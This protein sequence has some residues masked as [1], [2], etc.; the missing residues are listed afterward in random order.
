MFDSLLTHT[1]ATTTTLGQ[2]GVC[3]LLFCRLLPVTILLRSAFAV[4][5][6][7]RWTLAIA[8]LMTVMLAP[9]VNARQLSD[10]MGAGSWAGAALR[11]L[12]V[13]LALGFGFSILLAGFQLAGAI[14]GQ[15]SGLRWDEAT[16][17][18]NEALGANVVQRYHTLLALSVFWV[19]GGHRLLVEQLMSSLRSIP[20]GSVTSGMDPM[21][22]LQLLLEHSTQMG[23]RT[24]APLV[25]CL[26]ISSG[27]IA[28]V[29]RAAPMFG[30]H[31][32]AVAINLVTILIV[33]GATVGP[34]GSAYQRQWAAGMA[35]YDEQ[36]NA[37][38][39]E[40]ATWDET[41]LPLNMATAGGQG[42]SH[43]G[44]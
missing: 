31:G 3:V 1:V 22:V 16:Q 37:D 2:A 10:L 42:D 25:F 29:A 28:L 32:I 6:P 27:V 41:P 4:A 36:L 17:P 23:V 44:R 34:I 24:A 14:L 13:G 19:T 40:Q 11:E 12:L 43:V 9:G 30:A 20:L 18:V 21:R 38:P 15:I 26:L 35:L 7:W 39:S 5:A 33:S 8:C